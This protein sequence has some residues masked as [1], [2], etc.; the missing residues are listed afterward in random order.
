MSVSDITVVYH[1]K[2][3]ASMKFLINTKELTD[4]EITYI[5]YKE[6]SFESDIEIDLIPLIILNND[7]SQIYKGKRAFDKLEEI[8]VNK[9]PTK[10]NKNSL[11]YGNKSVTFMPE[12]GSDK[13]KID[14]D[15]K[16]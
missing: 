3:E 7:V 4:I 11:S 9:I 8:K 1:P 6:D 10:K 15:A 14:L 2:C 12:D 16:F 5:N 13:K